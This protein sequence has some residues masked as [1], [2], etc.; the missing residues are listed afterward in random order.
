MLILHE[1]THIGSM[2]LSPRLHFNHTSVETESN[3][4]SEIEIPLKTVYE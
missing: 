1:T 4:T 2:T 3:Q